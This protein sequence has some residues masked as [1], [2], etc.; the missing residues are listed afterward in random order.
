M[1]EEDRDILH[2]RYSECK[3]YK[4]KIRYQALYGVSRNLSVIDIAA[5]LDVEESTIYDWIHRWEEERNVKDKPRS[6]RPE[7]LTKEDDK[8]LKDLLDNKSPKDF[9][10]NAATWTTRELH[11]YFLKVHHE[12]VDEETIRQH[13][14]TINAHYVKGQLVYKEADTNAQIDFAKNVYQLTTDGGFKRVI[15]LDEMSVSTSAHRGYGWTTQERLLVTAP[16]SHNERA[17][18]FIAVDVINGDMIETISKNAKVDSFMRLLNKIERRCHDDKTLICMDNGRIHRAKKVDEFFRGKDNMKILYTSSYSPELNPQEYMN[19]YLRNKLFNNHNF[20]S[21]HH[22]GLVL[23][24][25]AR[26]LDSEV[27]KSVATLIPIES[28]LSF[29]L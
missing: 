20:R 26:K 9:G 21:V 24:R 22:I 8:D 10:I 13:L 3:D 28:M 16:Q 18:C 2:K 15:F 5:V 6:G 29:Q 25:F 23:S 17:N 7:K 27:V 11:E 12:E 1:L 19:G 14:H 4:E